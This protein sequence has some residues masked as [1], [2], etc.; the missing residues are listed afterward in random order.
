MQRIKQILRTE[1]GISG[2]VFA[3]SLGMLV[4]IAAITLDV[5]RAFVTR[6][7]LQNIA[8]SAALAAGQQLGQQYAQAAAANNNTIPAGFTADLTGIVTA[9]QGLSVLHSAGGLSGITLDG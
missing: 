3:L 5:G 2:I 9:A 4:A 7:E 1:Q 8:D 6:S